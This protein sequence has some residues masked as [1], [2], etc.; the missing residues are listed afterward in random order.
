MRG[1]VDGSDRQWKAKS[2]LSPSVGHQPARP[3]PL[4]WPWSS[5]ILLVS[6]HPWIHALT[7]YFK[8]KIQ[9]VSW[10]APE[11]ITTLA[12]HLHRNQPLIFFLI[13][14]RKGG[15]QSKVIP[16]AICWSHPPDGP[17]PGTLKISILWSLLDC[18]LLHGVFPA[19]CLNAPSQSHWPPGI[20]TLGVTPSLPVPGVPVCEMEIIIA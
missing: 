20:V 15:P 4:N 2:E 7:F 9:A 10:R 12:L 13:V 18:S 14:T 11:A 3:E 16:F 5:S 19:Q 8:D 6:S 1:F 17:S